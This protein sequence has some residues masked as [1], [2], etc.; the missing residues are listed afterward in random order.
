[1]FLGEL[2]LA[3][4]RGRG[5]GEKGNRVVRYP[6]AKLDETGGG[7]SLPAPEEGSLD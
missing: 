7:T 6:E 4:G 1:V 3:R 2:E 5:S